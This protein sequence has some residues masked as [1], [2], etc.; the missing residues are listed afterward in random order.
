MVAS[1][2]TLLPPI[3]GVYDPSSQIWVGLCL[4]WQIENDKNHTICFQRLSYKRPS[5]FCLVFW[6]TYSWKPTNML[7]AWLSRRRH[8]LRKLM[9]HGNA[10]V[11]I[12]VDNPS[13]S[14]L[15]VP[16]NK[17]PNMWVV[18][19]SHMP[20]A[21]TYGY[22][23]F[24]IFS[25]THQNAIYIFSEDEPIVK[26]NNHSWSV[27]YNRVHTWCYIYVSLFLGS[28]F[29]STDLSV[30]CQYHTVLST[31]TSQQF[32][33]MG[34]ISPPALF[35]LQ[36]YVGYSESSASP[37]KFYIHFVFINTIT[38]L[39]F[40][41]DYVA[42]VDPFGKNWHFYTESSYSWT[43]IISPFI[44]LFFDFIDQSFVVFFI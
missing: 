22:T 3:D 8:I 5:S 25:S 12:P 33:K 15:W 34:S 29:C 44:C 35:C 43:R 2:L 13:E 23:A 11:S 21:L 31:V 16:S 18:W 10:N 36:N 14:N 24:S 1:A 32:L 42:A 17:V 4:F 28:L 26:C 40:D 41:C 20:I 38:S 6:N 9:L 7:E 19:I 30:L 39:D 37:Y 27:V